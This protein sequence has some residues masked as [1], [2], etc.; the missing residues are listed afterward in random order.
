MTVRPVTNMEVG[1]VT[2]VKLGTEE[3]TCFIVKV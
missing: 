3:M 1:F 2:H